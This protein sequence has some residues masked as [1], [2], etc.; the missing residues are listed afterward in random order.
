MTLYNIFGFITTA[1]HYVLNK[2][3]C[4]ITL[5]SLHILALTTAFYDPKKCKH[6]MISLIS[7]YHIGKA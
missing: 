4:N 1:S 7:D 5:L 2:K 6:M 3:K